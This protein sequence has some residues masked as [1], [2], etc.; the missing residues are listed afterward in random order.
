MV[1]KAAHLVSGVVQRVLHPHDAALKAAHEGQERA[2]KTDTATTLAG[3]AP[4]AASAT[5]TAS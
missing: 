2:I 1:D 5:T 3:T 4:T